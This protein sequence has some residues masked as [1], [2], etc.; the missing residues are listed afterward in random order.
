MWS[1]TGLTLGLAVLYLGS[2]VALLDAPEHF[3]G[4]ISSAYWRDADYRAWMNYRPRYYAGE[5]KYVQAR[6]NLYYPDASPFWTKLADGLEVGP[7]V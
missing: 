6:T 7:A 3:M 1:V 2:Y 5:I 4:G